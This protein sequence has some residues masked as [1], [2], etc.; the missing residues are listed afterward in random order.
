MTAQSI[1]GHQLSKKEKQFTNYVVSYA[2]APTYFY[3][4]TDG[5]QDQFGG[6]KARKFMVKSMKDMFFENYQ[7]PMNEQHQIYDAVIEDWKKNVEQTD[8]ILVIG[9]K[10]TP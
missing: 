8:D 4:F 3:I 9:F 2:D 10:L 7:K 5:Y 1:G 6:G